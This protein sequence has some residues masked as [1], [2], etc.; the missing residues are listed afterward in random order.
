L[1]STGN[2]SSESGYFGSGAQDNKY[3]RFGNMKTFSF[4]PL[5]EA[6]LE[7]LKS[8]NYETM[9][10]IQEKSIPPILNGSDI[11]AQAKTGSGKTAAFGIGL[12]HNLDV[13]YYRVQA[14]VL[15]P[16][17]ELAEQV[18]GELRRIARFQHNIKLLNIT[19]GMSL[20]KQEH[21][22]SHQA[23]IVVGTPGRIAKVLKRGSLVMADIKTIVL[24]EADRMLDMGFIDQINEIFGYAPA[25]HQTLCFSATFSKEIKTLGRSILNNPIEVTVESQH[26]GNVIIQH[27]YKV[28]QKNK[29]ESL[30]DL[31]GHYHPES[32]LIFCNTKDAC[33]VVG[34]ELNRAGLHSLALHGDLEQK[35]RTEV[36]I[37]FSNGSSRVLVATDVA[38]RGLD[39]DDLGAVINYDMPFETESYVHRIGRTGRAGRS[40]LALSLMKPNEGFRLDEINQFTNSS[41]L[42][43]SP[44]SGSENR[45]PDLEPVMITLSING[46]RKNKI[47]PGDVLGAL[48]SADGIS[49]K[50]VGRID[51]LDYITF[52]AVKRQTAEH[53]FSLLEKGKIK[54]RRF[55]ALIND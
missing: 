51:R 37:R 47:S 23:H 46:G 11:F 35:E 55:K 38:A 22:L 45:L 10:A 1:F 27:F 3:V 43:E 41:F 44:V 54:G 49:G 15:C 14:M 42:P 40:G 24:D 29:T 6:M 30:I 9:T 36:L 4:L 18:T 16:T 48:T 7:N 25:K 31:L 53:A 13:E 33:R 20:R 50:D 52:V 5:T 28:S 12:L 39:I 34:S 17:R 2:Y 19:G 32:T 8:L 21:S 26:S